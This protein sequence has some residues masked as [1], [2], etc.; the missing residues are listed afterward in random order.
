MTRESSRGAHRLRRLK[1]RCDDVLVSGA[2][3]HIAS[4][5]AA[6]FLIGWIR[7]TPQEFT[8]HHDDTGSAE[9]A[10]KAV[11]FVESLLYRIQVTTLCQALDSGDFRILSLNSEQRTRL[12]DVFHNLTAADR[13]SKTIS[14]I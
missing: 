12:E 5:S 6:Y 7:V 8:Q 14:S 9:S 2:T 4:K 3:A 13:T 11:K 10:L 1:R